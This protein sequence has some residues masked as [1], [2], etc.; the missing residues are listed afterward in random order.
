MEKSPVGKERPAVELAGQSGNAFFIIGRVQ[1]A[2][3]KAGYTPEEIERYRDDATSDDYDHLID[4]TSR[5][6]EVQ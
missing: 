1:K 5:W 2:L 3:R 4:V 6:V